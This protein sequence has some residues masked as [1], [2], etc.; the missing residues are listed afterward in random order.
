MLEFTRAFSIY[1]CMHRVNKMTENSFRCLSKTWI[2]FSFVFLT[3]VDVILDMWSGIDLVECNEPVYGYSLIF[4]PLLPGV[5]RI[6]FL[7]MDNTQKSCNYYIKSVFK[8]LLF[9]FYQLYTNCVF[10][11]GNCCG[12][13][14]SMSKKNEAVTLKF[15]EA[16][17]EACPALIIQ[18]SVG[19]R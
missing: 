7:I 19:L 17:F 10:A 5:V 6:L 2:L 16:L 4:L 13:F 3:S 15:L 18:T 11:F 14:S 8:F 9:P 1:A 12:D